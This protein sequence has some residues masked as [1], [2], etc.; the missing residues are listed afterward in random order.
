MIV[1][2]AMMVIAKRHV[3]CEVA[4]G[5]RKSDV[6]KSSLF[7][8]PFALTERH[9]RREISVGRVDDVHGIELEALG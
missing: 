5:P 4:P 8:E 7:F 3:D 1:A 6:E 2:T 9:I